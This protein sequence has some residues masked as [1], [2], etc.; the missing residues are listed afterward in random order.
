MSANNNEQLQ[1]YAADALEI[2]DRQKT[3]FNYRLY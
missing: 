2:L 1:A 3:L